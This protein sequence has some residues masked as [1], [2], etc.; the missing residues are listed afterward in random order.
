MSS[1]TMTGSSSR[2]A[3]MVDP[4]IMK[5]LVTRLTNTFNAAAGAELRALEAKGLAS[6]EYRMGLVMAHCGALGSV[7]AWDMPEGRAEGLRWLQKD[8]MEIVKHFQS[9]RGQRIDLMM[10]TNGS[11]AMN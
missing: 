7:L 2:S 9:M 10:A 1:A 6:H 5:E 8:G 4:E 11:E 3:P